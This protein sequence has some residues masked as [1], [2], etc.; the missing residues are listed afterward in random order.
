MPKKLKPES[1]AEQSGRFRREAQRLIDAGELNPIEGEVIL[2]KL[3]R[4]ALAK[5]S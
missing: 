4:R 2:D 3:V 1:E 5:P